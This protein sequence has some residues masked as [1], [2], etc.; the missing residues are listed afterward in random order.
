LDE[1]WARTRQEGTPVPRPVVGSIISGMLAGLQAAHDVKD[2][3][4]HPL[5][6]V[7]RDVSPQNVLVGVDG[8]ARVL[9]FGVASV[10]SNQGGAIRG[11]LGYAAPEGLRGRQLDRRA[12]IFAAGVLCWELLCGKRLFVGE[13]AGEIL[14]KLLAR[15]IPSVQRTLAEAGREPVSDEL[16][17][18]VMK[19]LEREP[20][21]RYREAR[22]FAK[23]LESVLP[24]GPTHQVGEWV[25]HL[26]SAT[27][28]D[29]SLLV[30]GV[31]G[32]EGKLD[33]KSIPPPRRSSFP[34]PGGTRRVSDRPGA[35]MDASDAS[36]GRAVSVRLGWL[37]VVLSAVV[38]ITLIWFLRPKG[39]NVDDPDPEPVVPAQPGTPMDLGESESSRPSKPVVPLPAAQPSKPDAPA[40]SPE[41]D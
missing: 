34:P 11:K 24:P 1:L 27:L 21:R 36:D 8:V 5:E 29:R 22:D 20:S 15:T 35:V 7:H 18:V 31:E 12:D 23:A 10:G 40:A 2:A 39:S 30:A 3:A 17:A 37:W 6:L 26:A 13:D 9:D 41:S 4:G 32:F 28:A 33:V 14:G 16:D 19:A 38:L 25:S